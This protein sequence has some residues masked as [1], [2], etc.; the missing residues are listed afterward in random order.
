MLSRDDVVAAVEG[1]ARTTHIGGSRETVVAAAVLAAAVVLFLV[2]VVLHR[3][4]LHDDALI[5]LRYARNLLDGN[6]LAWNPGERVEGYTNFLFVLLA[7]G[8]GALGLDL[9][10]AVRAVNFAAL[11]CLALVFALVLRSDRRA[12]EPIAATIALALTLAN[13]PLVAWAFGGLEG[14]LLAALVAAG[15]AATQAQ[16]RDGP[17]ARLAAAGG[18]AFGLAVLTRPDAA[19]FLG[20]AAG[21][22]ILGA[23]RSERRRAAWS[24]AAMLSAA[25]LVVL[26]QELWRLTYYGDWLPNTF[27][28]KVTGLGGEALRGGVFYVL[29]YLV[30]PPFTLL[31]ALAALVLALRDR[32]RRREATY[33]AASVAVYLAYIVS[34]G[35]DHMPGSRLIVPLIPLFGFL[36][37]LGAGAALRGA[38]LRTKA[39]AGAALVGLLA[40]QTVDPAPTI[41]DPAA[42]LGTVIGRHIRDAWPS[43]SL[44]ALNTAGSTPYFAPNHRYIDMLGLNDRTIARRRIERIRL[45][46]QKMPGHGKG[47][48]AYVLARAPDFIILGGARGALAGNPWFLSDL[49]I[50]ENPSFAADYR[51]RIES[52]DVTGMR[53]FTEYPATRSGRL[54]FMYYERVAE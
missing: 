8:L 53:D 18:L 13:A 5:A 34:V 14:P 24:A 54:A 40:T 16:F 28:T 10:V 45:P 39:T 51:L 27:Y 17:Q 3:H 36:V 2:L 23:A 30:R 48:G 11:A 47:D 50:V 37:H 43:G 38:R 46:G 19:L 29:I 41:A 12:D 6:G 22:L 31:L 26:P 20:C 9:I 33:L 52:L 15:V 42:Q 4:F 49:E 25:A 32:E 21:A 35:G 1:S 7:S 44:V